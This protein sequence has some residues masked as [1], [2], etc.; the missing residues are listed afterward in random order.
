[1]KLHL[2]N[3]NNTWWLTT[4][5]L[6][7]VVIAP[8]IKGY[9]KDNY[10]LFFKKHQS[11]II[12]QHA[13]I[14]MPQHGINGRLQPG[15]EL[16]F[17]RL[18]A[19]KRYAGIHYALGYMAQRSLQRSYY[20]KPSL[21]YYYTVVQHKLIVQPHLDLGVLLTRQTNKEFKFEQGVY[22]RVNPLRMQ[23]LPSLGIDL[24][25]PIYKTKKYTYNAVLGYAFGLQLPFSELS[26]ILPINQFRI[27]IQFHSIN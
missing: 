12:V 3:R 17:H 11:E 7:L 24:H 15:F 20:V 13:G 22:D 25:T 2:R 8:C 21:F 14:G 1:M 5:V 26:T 16:G 6:L 4:G 10:H 9:S 27:G 19:K 23:C 18:Q